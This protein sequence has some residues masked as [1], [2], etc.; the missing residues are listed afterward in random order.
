MNSEREQ[1]IAAAYN[2]GCTD[3]NANDTRHWPMYVE[4]DKEVHR[5]YWRGHN[6]ARK[7][8]KRLLDDD[9]GPP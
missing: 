6:D 9:S 2:D 5:A 7:R 4:D 8:L 1:R 3:A